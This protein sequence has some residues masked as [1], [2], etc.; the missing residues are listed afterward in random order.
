MFLSSLSA[1]IWLCTTPT[2]MR[3]S[4]PGLVAL[5]KHHLHHNPLSG[6]LFVFINRKRTQM[7]VLYFDSGGY[8]IWGK[9]LEQGTFARMPSQDKTQAL[10]WATLKCLIEGLDIH[11]IKQR[12]R[13]QRRA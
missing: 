10:S 7:K 3:R 4:Y 13:F 11:V 9:R 1:R 8:C 6:D 2:D 12:R 5:A